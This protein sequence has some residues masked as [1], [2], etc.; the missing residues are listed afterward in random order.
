MTDIERAE[1]YIRIFM[2]AGARWEFYVPVDGERTKDGVRIGSVEVGPA[3]NGRWFLRHENGEVDWFAL[4]TVYALTQYRVLPQGPLTV[5][6]DQDHDT[7]SV[8]GHVLRVRTTAGAESWVLGSDVTNKA[9][10]VSH[11]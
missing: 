11:G 9:P 8:G 3:E 1:Q 4:R 5:L 6:A 2:K 10:A 7:D